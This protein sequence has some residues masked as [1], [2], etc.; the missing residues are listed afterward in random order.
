[1][2]KLK[3]SYMKAIFKN[4]VLIIRRKRIT[5]SVFNINDTLIDNTE[6]LK[7]ALDLLENEFKKADKIYKSK[8]RKYKKG[9]ITPEELE[10]HE[11]GVNE[12]LAQ[13]E[14]IKSKL[15]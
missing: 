11:F 15:E 2:E 6:G 9:L 3:L 8:V 1:M 5:K 12:L 7:H 13:I 4:I 10:I 14:N